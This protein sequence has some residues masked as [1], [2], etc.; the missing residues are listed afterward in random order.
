[1]SNETYYTISKDEIH[2]VWEVSKVGIIPDMDPFKEEEKKVLEYGY[3]SP[4]EEI[5]IAV[6]LTRKNI[7]TIYPR[8]IYMAG[9]LTGKHL[10]I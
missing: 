4:F 5:S 3:N 6:D 9:F 2:L 8:A 10:L 1:M 7:G